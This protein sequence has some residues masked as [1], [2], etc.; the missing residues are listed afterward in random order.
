MTAWEDV[1]VSSCVV[2]LGAATSLG[3]DAWSTAAAVRAKITGFTDHP[4]MIDSVGEPMR[5]ALS[6]WLEVDLTGPARFEALL[7]PALD[8][9]LSIAQARMPGLRTRLFL[10]LPGP[11]PGLSGEL[12]RRLVTTVQGRYGSLVSRVDTF[13]H[14]HAAGL[15]GLADAVRSIESGRWDLCVVAGVESYLEPETLEWIE[16]NDQFHGAGALNNAWG[17]IPGEGSGAVLLAT[18]HVAAEQ[19]LEILG[20]L[21]RVGAGFEENQIKTPTVCLGHGLTHAFEQTF[22]ALPPDA[23]VTDIYCDMNGEPYRA[24]EYGFACLRSGSRLQ[25]ASSFHAP[26]DCLGD[27]SAASGPLC[28]ALAV[29]AGAKGYSSGKWALAWASSESG[30]RAAALVETRRGR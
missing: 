6:P 15:L 12:D 5:V 1:G 2:G 11:R 24:D 9:V 25:S 14:G 18:H 22:A 17:F 16:E 4:F 27:V 28:I 20:R 8:Q 3:R 30:E 13:P 21:W 26:A 10:A 23:G 19:E 29:I 7:L